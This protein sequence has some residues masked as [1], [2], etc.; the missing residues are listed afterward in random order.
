MEASET[1][2][3]NISF[4]LKLLFLGI[5]DSS[6]ESDIS[7]MVIASSTSVFSENLWQSNQE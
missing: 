6:E 4:L 7:S 2:S 5:C 3:Q 1:L